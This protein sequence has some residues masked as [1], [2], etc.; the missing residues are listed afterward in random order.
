MESSKKTSR[1]H[2]NSANQSLIVRFRA[3]SL[4]HERL[5]KLAEEEELC[6]SAFVRRLVL[7]SL[8]KFP[9]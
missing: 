5:K 6:L 7:D 8:E 9:G 1:K 4:L 3:S 2:S